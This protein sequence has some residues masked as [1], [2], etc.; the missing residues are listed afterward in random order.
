MSAGWSPRFAGRKCRSQ[1]PDPTSI[2]SSTDDP[3]QTEAPAN[4]GPPVRTRL[5]G[6]IDWATL[7]HRVWGWDVLACPCGGRMRFIAV[8][9]QRTVIERILNHGGLPSDRV[10]PL[11]ARSWNDTR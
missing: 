11:R 8:I 1:R 6:R 7:M 3:W 2:S 4:D 5:L 9:T 10:V